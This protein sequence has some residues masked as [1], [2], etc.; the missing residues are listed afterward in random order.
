MEQPH[1]TH[2]PQSNKRVP[3]KFKVLL[4]ILAILTVSGFAA[5]GA[6]T[7]K[8]I[9]ARNNP[10][11]IAKDKETELIDKV[12]K[13]VLLPSDETPSIATV[14]DKEKLKDQEFFKDAENGDQLLIYTTAQQAI[15]YRESTNKIVRIAPLAIDSQISN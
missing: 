6:V 11:V 3:K 9:E 5:A 14:A 12:G 15:L 2:A 7:L 10:E 8:Y 4:I 13:L 1:I